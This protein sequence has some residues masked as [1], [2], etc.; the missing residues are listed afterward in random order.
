MDN[1]LVSIVCPTYNYEKY[2]KDAIEGFL[3]QKTN[4]SIE[5][6]IHDDASTDTTAD[7]IRK[8]EKKY[9]ELIKPIYQK[10]N[11]YS[12]GIKSIEN[13]I[14]PKCSGKYIAIC[15]GDDYW[16]DPYK[17]QKQVDFLE[18]NPQYS[19]CFHK[20][21]ILLKN[22]RLVGDFITKVPSNTTTIKDLARH[23]N[24]IHTP[25]VVLR[26]DFEIPSWFSNCPIG[27]YPLYFIAVRDRKIKYLDEPMA[28][29][30][31]G[32][33]VFSSQP[34]YNQGVDM[35]VTRQELI[36]NYPDQA[37]KILFMKKNKKIIHSLLCRLLCRCLL[38]KEG[39]PEQLN[40]LLFKYYGSIS[41]KP[42][43]DLAADLMR[44]WPLFPLIFI[45]QFIKT[46]YSRLKEILFRS[47][48]Q[49]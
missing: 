19:L 46:R 29:Y 18:A 38:I 47:K 39:F 4:F 11:Q 2:I 1:P 21:K 17:L 7:I 41:D 40:D 24:Y 48:T 3:M 14:W 16:I 30:R 15:E 9:P 23:G 13:F 42:F 37:I 35:F 22:G 45:K 26:N 31:F 36:K 25:S 49:L 12:K 20:I 32:V 27:D 28:V 6:I 44:S 10:E 33:G 8:Y 34:K 5:I 43:Y